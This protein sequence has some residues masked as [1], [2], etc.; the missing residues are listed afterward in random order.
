MTEEIKHKTEENIPKKITKEK[1]QRKLVLIIGAI[2]L[3]IAIVGGGAY[4]YVSS[5][6]VYI[7]QSVI[8]GYLINLAP[9]S[10]D[11]LNQIF[12]NVGDPVFQNETVAQ[13]GNE[14]VKAKTN[15][16]IVAVNQNIGQIV[17]P[18]SGGY[19]AQMIDPSSL[20][21]VG[22]I[23]ENKGLSKIKVGDPATFTVDAFGSKVYKGVVDEVSETSRASDVVFNVSTERPTNEFD[24]KVRFDPTQYPELKNG[25]SARIWVYVN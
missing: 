12:V 9:Q 22:H 5:K 8:S 2:I 23:D 6:T 17:N 18:Q 13:V 20:R 7:D 14:L 4:L 15:G 24:V 1:K 25:M 19:A 10:A 21:V 16:V 11:V 3:F